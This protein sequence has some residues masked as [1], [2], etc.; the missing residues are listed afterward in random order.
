ML[1]VGGLG[2]ISAAVGRRHGY[3]DRLYRETFEVGGRLWE[4]M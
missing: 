2:G 4:S 3:S 1:E